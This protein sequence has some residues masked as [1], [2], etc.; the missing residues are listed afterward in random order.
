MN[1]PNFG[2]FVQ[3]RP[4]KPCQCRTN[5]SRT[6]SRRRFNVVEDEGILNNINPRLGDDPTFFFED[7]KAALGE[8]VSETHTHT[9]L[10]FSSSR[11]VF[12]NSSSALVF[13]SS[14][15][16]QFGETCFDRI[17]FVSTSVD[18]HH[19][20]SV[21][22]AILVDRAHHNKRH[23]VIVPTRTVCQ[24]IQHIPPTH[25]ICGCALCVHPVLNATRVIPF[26]DS[27]LRPFELAHK[28]VV[29][30]DMRVFQKLNVF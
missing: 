8:R 30:F 6:Y 23:I 18:K 21:V 15:C 11:A 28:F 22:A 2:N 29:I 7:E 3:H 20:V 19:I 14:R 26:N 24:R 1:L 13:G 5:F 4:N 9:T 12:R 10:S 27:T 17:S 16:Q 25:T